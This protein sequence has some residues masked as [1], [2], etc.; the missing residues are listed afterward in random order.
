MLQ[1]LSKYELNIND[2]YYSNVW[3]IHCS[4]WLNLRII[5]IKDIIYLCIY[6]DIIELLP[7]QTA[8][9]TILFFF[10]EKVSKYTKSTRS[11]DL[12]NTLSSDVQSLMMNYHIIIIVSIVIVIIYYECINYSRLIIRSLIC[13][14]DNKYYL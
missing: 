9:P 12:V 10:I 3:W 7:V 14:H 6:H 1:L 13:M 4:Y 5:I 11:D 8:L 2:Y